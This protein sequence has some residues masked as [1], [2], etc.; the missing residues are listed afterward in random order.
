MYTV[1]PTNLIINS[2]FLHLWETCFHILIIQSQFCKTRCNIPCQYRPWYYIIMITHITSAG[3]GKLDC[4][5]LLVKSNNECVPK[6]ATVH[7]K[8]LAKHNLCVYRVG[9]ENMEF[10]TVAYRKPSHPHASHCMSFD[11]EHRDRNRKTPFRS[12]CNHNW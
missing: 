1:C 12:L 8:I 9:C 3:F 6:H 5:I 2:Q 10:Y 4:W 11:C 7:L